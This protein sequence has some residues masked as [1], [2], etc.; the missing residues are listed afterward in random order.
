MTTTA[1]TAFDRTMH[2]THTWLNAIM[3]DL[4][5][6]PEAAYALLRATLHALRDRMPATAAVKLGAQLPM[7]I[8]GMYYEG[9]S[10]GASHRQRTLASFLEDVKSELRPRRMIDTERAVRGV[11]KVV[12]DHLAAGEA[13]RVRELLPKALRPLW[14]T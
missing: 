6:D 5:T 12:A 2:K 7:L 8:R 14:P 9:F 10:P 11:L 1:I 3:D 4:D 13:H